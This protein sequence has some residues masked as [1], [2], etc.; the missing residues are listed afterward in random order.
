MA[1]IQSSYVYVLYNYSKTIMIMSNSEQHH[2]ININ[3]M[4]HNHYKY[5]SLDLHREPRKK[6]DYSK[7]LE[8]FTF[9][10]YTA[11]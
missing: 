8:Y 1:I 5:N 6:K 10:F 9:R 2:L 7:L 4:S 11:F 3:Y